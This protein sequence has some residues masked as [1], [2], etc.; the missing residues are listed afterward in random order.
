[1]AKVKVAGIQ[2]ACVDAR[3]KN[4]AKAVTLGRLAAEHGARVVCYQQLL[5]N[6]WFPRGRDERHLALAEGDDGPTLD[7]L[8]PLAVETGVTLVCPLFER[9][10]AGPCYNTAVVVGPDGG[11]L[12]KYRKMHVPDLPLWEEKYYFQPGD[13]GFPVFRSQGL[14]FGCSCA[15]TTSSPRE[16]GSSRWPAPNWSSPRTPR[17]SPRPQVGGGA[18][19]H[20][21]R[22]QRVRFASTAWAA[23][24]AR[25][26]TGGASGRSGMGIPAAAERHARRR[27][28]RRIEPGAVRVSARSGTSCATAAR[29][30]TGVGRPRPCAAFAPGSSSPAGCSRASP[31]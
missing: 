7:A 17:R 31:W 25:T 8:R 9:S 14:R 4:L 22:Q 23:R 11:L 16:R 29:R 20:R 26:S 15:G 21:H 28:F 1:M 12:G 3:E 30:L 6:S 19:R 2:M 18:R 27:N 5:A 24:S 13:T 10:A